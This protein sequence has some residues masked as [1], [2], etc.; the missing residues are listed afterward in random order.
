MKLQRRRVAVVAIAAALVCLA[1]C[2][3]VVWRV[4][5]ALSASKREAAQKELLAVEV[6][7]LGAQPNPGFEAISAPAV[8]KSAA[9]FQ[10]NLVPGRSGGALCLFR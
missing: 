7:M 4:E 6:R 9:M 8:F 3:V 1:V 5:R 10:G 2:G